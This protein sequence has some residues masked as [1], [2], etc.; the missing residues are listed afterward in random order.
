VH[1]VAIWLQ[2]MAGGLG[3][4][5]SQKS[6]LYSHRIALHMRWLQLVGSLKLSVSFA[7]YRLFYRALLQKR[8]V[9]LKLQIFSAKEP[10]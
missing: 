7:Q 10:V 6:A 1:L 8:P 4:S 3:F 9:I 5:I 2:F